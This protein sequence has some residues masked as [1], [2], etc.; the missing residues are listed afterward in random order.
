[1]DVHISDIIKKRASG[2]LFMLTTSRRFGLPVED[3][4]TIYIGLIRPR[5]LVE[6]AVPAWH[7]GLSEQQHA[8][9]ERIQ[10][11]ACR[12]ML[13]NKC[14]SYLMLLISANSQGSGHVVNKFVSSLW[15]NLWR[16]LH[17][18]AGYLDK[19]VRTLEGHCGIPTSSPFPSLLLR[20]M[21]EV[22]SPL[23]LSCRMQKLQRFSLVDYCIGWS[24]VGWLIMFLLEW[25][26]CM[27]F[28]YL[29]YVS[30]AYF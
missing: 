20:D 3:L 28:V 22:S 15:T 18:A 14:D 25:I 16:I 7:P 9:L 24:A 17:S 29:M 10:K 23:W 13:R 11:W 26:S 2:R 30:F 4:K 27:Y 5:P 6:Y 12:I 19:D 8:A 21:R 1:M